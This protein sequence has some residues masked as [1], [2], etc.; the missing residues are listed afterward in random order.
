MQKAD[1]G[2]AENFGGL[3]LL[4]IS[5]SACRA[6]RREGEAKKK[7]RENANKQKIEG[8]G[9]GMV[10]ELL[11][12]DAGKRKIHRTKKKKKTRE[13]SKKKTHTHTTVE[14]EITAVATK[15]H[16]VIV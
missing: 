9:G 5:R 11:Q 13:P 4:R 2:V 1:Y 6:R 15:N 7:K 10:E 3:P 12:Y 16:T 8:G 14:E